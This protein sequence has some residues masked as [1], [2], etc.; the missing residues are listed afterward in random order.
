MH[1]KE[2]NLVCSTVRV[3]SLL[4]SLPISIAWSEA[5]IMVV[6]YV[7]MI[8]PHFLYKYDIHLICPIKVLVNL[9]GLNLVYRFHCIYTLKPGLQHVIVLCRVAGIQFNHLY[10]DRL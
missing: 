9:P 8:M 6:Y 10:H 1:K 4:M 7:G 5:A 3:L 2:S